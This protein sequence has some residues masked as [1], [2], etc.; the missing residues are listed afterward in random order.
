MRRAVALTT[1]ASL[2]A[3]SVVSDFDGLQG[4]KRDAGVIVADAGRLPDAEVPT[5]AASLTDPDLL[6]A[7]SFDEQTGSVANDVTG[8]GNDAQLMSGASFAA[9]RRG[10]AISFDGVDDYAVVVN[11]ST[12]AARDAMTIA[13]FLNTDETP[14]QERLLALGNMWDVKLN[15]SSRHPQ[16]TLTDGTYATMA[17]VMPTGQWHHLAMTYGAGTVTTYYDGAPEALIGNTITMKQV[18][19][20][21]LA[22]TF[23]NSSDRTL[24]CKCR[25]DDVRLYRRVLS[26]AEI[27]ALAK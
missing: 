7:W 22:F 11:G 26:A 14:T 1:A 24:P 18:T 9:G 23:G 5:D 3:C 21:P 25:L 8:K 17:T 19:G 10:S 16:L 20:D 6:A 4:G 12:L 2:G 15:G 27:A 13:F